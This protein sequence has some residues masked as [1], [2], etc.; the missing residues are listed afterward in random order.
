MSHVTCD[1][2]MPNM[3]EDV[4]SYQNMSHVVHVPTSSHPLLYQKTSNGFRMQPIAF[5]VSFHQSQISIDYLVLC[6]FFAT[7]CWEEPIYIIYIYII[8][9]FDWDLRIRCNDTPNAIAC[10]KSEMFSGRRV[11]AKE[12]LHSC[13]TCLINL[14]IFRMQDL[15]F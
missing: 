2:D 14:Q 11:D 1:W 13:V 3:N 9:K 15:Q 4:I 6:V 7:F 8:Y 12:L 5:R 10:T